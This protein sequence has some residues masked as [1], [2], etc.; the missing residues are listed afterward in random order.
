MLTVIENGAA[1]ADARSSP[2]SSR[3][4]PRRRPPMPALYDASACWPSCW[5]VVWS[6]AHLAHTR[7]TPMAR[8]R[9]A[10]FEDLVIAGLGQLSHD[11]IGKGLVS[12]LSVSW[13]WPWQECAFGGAEPVSLRERAQAPRVSSAQSWGE[14]QACTRPVPC[15]CASAIVCVHALVPCPRSLPPP[16]QLCALFCLVGEHARRA[17]ACARKAPMRAGGPA[18]NDR[19]GVM[20]M[21][22]R[23]CEGGVWQVHPGRRAVE[24]AWS[25]ACGGALPARCRGSRVHWHG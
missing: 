7:V 5:G 22:W 12:C 21:R 16:V 9:G 3:L 1:G 25:G 23:V 17:R 15:D 20:L 2:A 19:R 6:N 14:V 24:R 4:L 11:T 10:S 8:P 13:P 18:W